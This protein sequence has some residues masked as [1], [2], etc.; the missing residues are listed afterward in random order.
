MIPNRKGTTHRKGQAQA[1][2]LELGL[3]TVG[4][5]G[6]EGLKEFAQF[7]PMLAQLLDLAQVLGLGRCTMLV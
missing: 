1:D 2:E 7:A 4:P 3:E 6:I 5:K